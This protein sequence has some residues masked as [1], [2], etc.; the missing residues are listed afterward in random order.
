MSETDVKI[1]DLA[2]WF[3]T[4]GVAFMREWKAL[5]EEEKAWFKREFAKMQG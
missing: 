2:K 1:S 3:E 5:S 4:P